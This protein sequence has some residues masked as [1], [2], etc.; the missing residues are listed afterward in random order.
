MKLDTL[1][2]NLIK[3]KNDQIESVSVIQNG[4]KILYCSF[5]NWGV[6]VIKP[7][8]DVKATLTIA[9]HTI[10]RKVMFFDY[11]NADQLDDKQKV[12][13]L[14]QRM[15]RF[16]GQVDL[17]FSY[18]LMCENDPNPEELD[19]QTAGLLDGPKEEAGT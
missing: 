1:G 3:V 12:A 10:P 9:A 4:T 18:I 19:I 14:K 5:Y 2:I 11:L 8:E 7:E 17:E 16:H 6:R 13:L 15:N